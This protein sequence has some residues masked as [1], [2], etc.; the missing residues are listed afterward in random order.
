M[1]DFFE[2]GLRFP[3]PADAHTVGARSAYPGE[4]DDPPRPVNWEILTAA[5]AA[6]AW[7]QVDEWVTWLRRTFALPATTVP[8]FWHRHPELVWELSALH[9]H[10]LACYDPDAS[11]SAPNAWLRDLADS[12]AR[13]R[14]W[15][16][17]SGTRLTQDQPSRQTFW[18]GEQPNTAPPEP[19]IADRAAD[20]RSF[21]ADDL[22]RR[23]R[24]EASTRSL[25]EDEHARRA[26][27]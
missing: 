4:F 26:G 5:E 10:W 2:G 24:I 17:T 11:P 27:P 25:L 23:Q 20:F 6:I 1:E 3:L 7:V 21:V 19:N 16:A 22:A 15:V 18:P 8:P 9:T 12:C 13:L 14:E